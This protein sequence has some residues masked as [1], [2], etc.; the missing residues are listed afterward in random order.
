[1]KKKILI[2]VIAVLVAV[3][4]GTGVFLRYRQTRT[5]FNEGPVVGNTA[6]NLNNTGL[7]CEKN[8]RIY[9]ANPTDDM[10]LYSM[11]PDGSDLQLLSEDVVSYIN[12]DSN[13]LYYARNNLNNKNKGGAYSFLH[14]N[15][16][17][18]VRC[19]LD[20]SNLIILDDAP[21]LYP[22]LVG[23]YVY[24]IHYDK[25]S[26]STLYRVKID[27]SEK[28]QLETSPYL[29]CSSDGTSIYYN[30][31]DTDHNIYQFDPT[32]KAKTCVAQGNYWMPQ[33]LGNTAYVMDCINDYALL[34]LNLSDG[35]SE[36]VCPDRMDCFNA[37]E[38]AIYFQKND[39][40]EPGLYKVNPDGSGLTKIM[41]GNFSSINVTD[42]YVYF[43]PYDQGGITM[44][45]LPRSAGEGVQPEIFAPGTKTD[46]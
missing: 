17:S 22:T 6:G 9:F 2:I 11:K 40:K 44:Y 34:K 42:A 36:T 32:S 33:V 28:E 10:H 1:M 20:G 12:A 3:G 7:F 15:T 14:V 27:G 43:E 31:L 29:P 16:N 19:N 35:S 46:K 30:G 38:D 41:D 25:K 45:R 5:I 8:D 39:E 4:I 21:C 26:A 13:Y 37:T 24:Y 18:L 23:N